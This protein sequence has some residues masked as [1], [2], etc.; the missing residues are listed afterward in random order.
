MRDCWPI[1]DKKQEAEFRKKIVNMLKEYQKE[2]PLDLPYTN[3]SLFQS[4]G[5]R[6]FVAFLQVFSTF[7]MKMYINKYDV[8]FL[9]KPVTKNSTLRKV[10]Y[11][12]LVKKKRSPLIKP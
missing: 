10:C 8:T 6:K 4:P 7:V 1:L 12:A 3:P 9:S 2:F 5:G 11:T